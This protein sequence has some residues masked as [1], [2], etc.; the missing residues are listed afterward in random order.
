MQPVFTSLTNT[1]RTVAL[2]VVSRQPAY[3]ATAEVRLQRLANLISVLQARVT[4]HAGG[5][6]AG[7]EL[8][9]L[10][11]Q[12]AAQ[13]PGLHDQLR[14]TSERA[15]E[16]GA[17]SLELFDL[18]AWTLRPFAAVLNQSRRIDPT[19]VRFTARLAVLLMLGV[20]IFE[21]WHIPRG[22]WLPLTIVVVLQPDYGSTRQRAA[23]RLLG[24]LVGGVIASLL[25]WLKLPP[26]LLMTATAGTIFAFSYYLRKN[27]AVAVFF[28]TLLIVL[29][30]ESASTVTI[31]FTIARLV[32]TA[33]GG[34]LAMVAAL[35]FWPVWERQRFPA[36][37]A[38]ALRANRD[39]LQ[40]LQA[41]LAGGGTYD[42]PLVAAK[43]RAEVA[44]GAVF[45]SLQRMAA[46]PKFQQEGL[47][48]AA[49][50]ANGN[51][52]LTR[53]FTT[54]A[55][56]L[57]PGAPLKQPEAA[58][59]AELAGNALEALAVS[60]GQSDAPA[61]TLAPLLAALE[62][63]QAPLP[64]STAAGAQRDHWVFGQMS[65]TALELSAMLLAASQT[66]DANKATA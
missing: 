42:P 32:A 43:R 20:A 60:V 5:S 34:G 36:Y 19:L 35:L 46:D 57:S 1:A 14:A 53:A 33:A 61:S 24:T 2:A 47:A 63:F 52:R 58:R 38:G 65:R 25:L 3:L 51:Q 54:I 30:T 59:F 15:A 40:L 23:Q 9:Q 21:Y 27:Y 10:L 6:A 41:R 18:D 28:I 4:A 66:K 62:D 12:V 16:R 56:H 55:L 45:A 39:Y 44:N 7:T 48:Q 50:I 64:E 11:R 37:L 17:F 49:A 13:V 26:V 8:A 31:D 22:Y 29:L